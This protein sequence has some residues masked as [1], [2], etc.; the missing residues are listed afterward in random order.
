MHHLT[1]LTSMI[2]GNSMYKNF[3]LLLV[4][5]IVYCGLSW[6]ADIAHAHVLAPDAPGWGLP[7]LMSTLSHVK[8]AS[9]RFTEQKTMAI[10]KAPLISSGSLSYVAPYRIEKITT[11]PVPGRFVLD[12]G[13]VTIGGV[14]G[15][16]THRFALSQYPQIRGLVVAIRATLAGDLPTLERFYVVKLGGGAARWR[17]FMRPKSVALSRFIRSITVKGRYDMI[18]AIRTTSRGGDTSEMRIAETVNDGR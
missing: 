3:N 1:G 14:A 2:F 10:L 8:A 12:H 9:G 5:A 11:S 7:Q 6:G 16:P 17:L 4:C 13:I 15:Q 18:T